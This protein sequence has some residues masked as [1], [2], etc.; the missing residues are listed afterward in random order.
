MVGTEMHGREIL[1][2]EGHVEAAPERHR[3]VDAHQ[4]VPLRQILL[5]GVLLDEVRPHSE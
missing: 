4:R 3:E 2:F 1:D 5:A